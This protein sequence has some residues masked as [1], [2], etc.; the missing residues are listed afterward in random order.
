LAA[1]QEFGQV[2]YQ[3]LASACYIPG[4]LDP[5]D[6][7]RDRRDLAGQRFRSAS[8]VRQ[9][10]IRD[11]TGSQLPNRDMHI[12]RRSLTADD[13]QAHSQM[14]WNGNGSACYRWISLHAPNDAC[15]QLA[16]FFRQSN[17]LAK[18]ILTEGSSRP[19]K[20]LDSW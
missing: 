6:E 4:G 1:L 8:I 3:D 7:F 16:A 18:E 13:Q 20:Q 15:S 12:A 14:N 2:V 17:E 10:S 11:M 19:V 5:R 9:M